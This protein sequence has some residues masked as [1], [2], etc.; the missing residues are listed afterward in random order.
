[1]YRVV[2]FLTGGTKTSR[3]FET[4]SEALRFSVF[5]VGYCQTH[6]IYKVGQ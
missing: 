6:E 5:K 3:T 4:L 2:Y 1:M